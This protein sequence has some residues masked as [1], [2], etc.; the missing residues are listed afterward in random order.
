MDPMNRLQSEH[1]VHRPQVS[2]EELVER[3]ARAVREDGTVEPPGG[4]RLRRESSP[5]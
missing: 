5:T 3:I 4:L 2:R 1:E